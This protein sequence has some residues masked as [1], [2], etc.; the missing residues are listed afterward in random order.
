MQMTPIVD[1]MGR[2]IASAATWPPN[3][4]MLGPKFTQLV[5]D[6]KDQSQLKRSFIEAYRENFSAV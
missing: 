6:E 5:A 1:E 2:V 4:E 3:D